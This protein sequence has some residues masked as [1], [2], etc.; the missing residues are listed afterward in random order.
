MKKGVIA[1]IEMGGTKTVV[2]VGQADGTVLEEFR[3]PTTDGEETFKTA[4]EWLRERGEPRAIGVAAFGPVSVNKARPDYG[5]MLKT[6]KPGWAGFSIVGALKEAFPNVKVE[7][8]T[9]VNAAVLAEANGLADVAYITIGTG[10]GG[11]V[12]ADGKLLHGAVHSE[13]GHWFPRKAAGDDFGGVCPFHGDCLEGL[14]S[15]PAMTKR[16]GKEPKELLADPQA[17]E[18]ETYYLAQ[19]C[20]T[21]LASVNPSRV[22]IGGGV[23]QAEGFHAMVEE[24]LRTMAKG[25]FAALEENTPFVVPPLHAQQAGIR[26]ALMLLA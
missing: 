18:F 5:Q 22:V 11:G 3:Y 26:G 21:L 23:S 2:A 17:W 20:M 6:P 14:A 16:W 19:A 9:D 13:F 4:I 15:G 8:E 24:K 7:I 10:I 12:M 1:G 25:Y